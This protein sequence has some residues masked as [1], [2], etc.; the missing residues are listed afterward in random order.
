MVARCRETGHSAWGATRDEAI[1]RLSLML[2]GF[3]AHGAVEEWGPGRPAEDPEAAAPSSAL[4][5]VIDVTDA[6]AAR[7]AD[8][9]REVGYLRHDTPEHE[10]AVRI[11]GRAPGVTFG[12][13]LFRE[14]PGSITGGRFERAATVGTD[15]HV[16][17]QQPASAP[18][19]LGDACP[20]PIAA[21]I[22]S[23]EQDESIGLG[24]RWR[25][26]SGRKRTEWRRRETSARVP[27]LATVYN[28]RVARVIASVPNLIRSLNAVCDLAIWMSGSP[29][30]AAGG[31]AEDGWNRLRPAL[32]DAMR[33][34]DALGVGQ[35]P[36][37]DGG[38]GWADGA[39]PGSSGG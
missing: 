31:E 1:D 19:S 21:D 38:P 39:G 22:W 17:L 11:S 37:S 9:L 33:L 36:A 29:S 26:V 24:D 35:Q 13:R 28:E 34:M 23:I 10:V 16:P 6:V 12:T 27:Y 15:V 8:A 32:S 5:T 30:F 14:G 18:G 4:G 2:A 7:L 20:G 25:V 3:L